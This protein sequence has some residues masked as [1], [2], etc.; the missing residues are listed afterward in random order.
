MESVQVH[1]CGTRNLYRSKSRASAGRTHCWVYII[2]SPIR[3]AALTAVCSDTSGQG[4]SKGRKNNFIGLLQLPPPNW[5][6]VT[7]EH[8][9]TTRQEEG[10]CLQEKGTAKTVYLTGQH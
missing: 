2:D 8:A 5:A 3:T 4:G 10:V 7:A 9:K 1:L 6:N